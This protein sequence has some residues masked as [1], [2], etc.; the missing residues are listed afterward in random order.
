MYGTV[1]RWRL[2]P[3][4]RA[5]LDAEMAAF[6]DRRVPGFVTEYVYQMDDTTV[7]ADVHAATLKAMAKHG[8]LMYRKLFY[9]PGSGPEHSCPKHTGCPIACAMDASRLLC[10]VLVYCR[11]RPVESAPPEPNV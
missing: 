9:G 8:T 11:S 2:K 10:R 1:A 7:P 4:A 6:H 5:Q 3:G